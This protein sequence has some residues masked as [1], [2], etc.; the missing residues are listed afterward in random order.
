MIKPSRRDKITDAIANNVAPTR[1]KS[2]NDLILRLDGKQYTKLQQRGKTTPAGRFYFT[3]THTSE[4]NCDIEGTLVQRGSTDFLI[5]GG[6]SRVLRRLVGDDYQYTRLGK[7]Y[8]STKQICYLVHVPAVIKKAHSASQGRKLMVPHDAFMD[9]DLKASANQPIAE[10]KNQMKSKVLQYMEDNLDKLGGRIVLHHD[11]DPVMYDETGQWTFGEQ[12]TVQGDTGEMRT[13][14]VLDRPLG[15]TPLLTNNIQ[16]PEGL[17]REAFLDSEGK[18]VAVQLS[19]ILKLPLDRI[20]L[21]LDHLADDD[22]RVTG[23]SLRTIVNLGIRH[24]MNVYIMAGGRK[25]SQHKHE[26]MA[27]ELACALQ[28]KAT[29]LGSTKQRAP[30]AT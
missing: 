30:A 9:Q 26:K 23:V 6:R 27:K 20:E 4:G 16:F 29:M 1:S 14:T 22:W 21:E 13:N 7:Q 25:I 2:S 17:C 15:Q 24:G 10:R 11:S 5:S 18:C 8:F 12:T 28:W 3:Q 19:S